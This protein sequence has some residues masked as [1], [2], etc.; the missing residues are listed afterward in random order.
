MTEPSEM[1]IWCLKCKG[2][3]GTTHLEEF[4]MKNGRPAERGKCVTCG[5]TKNRV[6]K[7]AA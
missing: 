1:R 3:T 6:I 4:V 2:R 7:K 5:T